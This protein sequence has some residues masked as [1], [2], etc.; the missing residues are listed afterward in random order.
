M[1]HILALFMF[2]SLGLGAVHGVE[3]T[4]VIRDLHYPDIFTHKEHLIGKAKA[5]KFTFLK[6]VKKTCRSIS[7]FS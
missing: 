4:R 5:N 6:K 3:I 2:L 1:K 7:L